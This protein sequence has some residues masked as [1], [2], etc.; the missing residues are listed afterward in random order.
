MDSCGEEGIIRITTEVFNKTIKI[1]IQ[2]SGKGIAHEDVGH[3]FEPFFTT[4]EAVKGIGLGLSVSYGIVNR[5]GGT[6][7]VKSKKG[8][9]AMFSIILPIEGALYEKQV[10]YIG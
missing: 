6:I 1:H 3:I 5:H 9:G 7:E 2:D 8:V 4:K 10:N